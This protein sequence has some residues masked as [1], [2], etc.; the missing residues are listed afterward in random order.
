MILLS[1]QDE[2]YLIATETP[3]MNSKE[4]TKETGISRKFLLI[5]AGLTLLAIS[6]VGTYL[7][8]P[9]AS[10]SG[11]DAKVPMIV[12]AMF[13]AWGAWSAMSRKK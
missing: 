1:A 5:A 4:E 3:L 7:A 9:Y 10:E 11:V 8:G 6:A 13:L 12:G 2:M